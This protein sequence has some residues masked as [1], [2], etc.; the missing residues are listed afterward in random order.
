MT[1][2]TN[3][4]KTLKLCNHLNKLSQPLSLAV[5]VIG[6]IKY[7]SKEKDTATNAIYKSNLLKNR[8]E[9]N[10]AKEVIKNNNK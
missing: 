6:I 9:I 7:P 4:L 8:N 2:I 10:K 3:V 5:F 1:I